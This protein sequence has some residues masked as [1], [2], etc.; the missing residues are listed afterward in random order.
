M[1]AYMWA[2]TSFGQ[3]LI[4]IYVKY[5]PGNI[6]INSITSCIAQNIAALLGGV[7]Y[8]R[9]GIKLSF[10]I[11]FSISC[12]GGLLIWFVGYNDDTLMPIFVCLAMFGCSGAFTLVYVS[13]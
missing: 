6:Y 8:S 11:L 4:M 12:A 1:M 9:L 7:I 5:L 13:T 3:Y 2:A 10:T